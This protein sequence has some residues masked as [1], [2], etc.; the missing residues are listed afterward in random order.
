MEERY[1]QANRRNWNERASIHAGSP[2]Y[3]LDAYRAEPTR[4]SGVVRFDRPRLGDIA[5]LDAVHLQCHIGTDTLSL[6]RLG[7]NVTGLDQSEESIEIARRL[8]ADTGTDGRFEIGDVHA[9]PTL[10]ER[11]YDLVYTGVGALNWLPS[12]DAWSGV[13]DDLL[14]PGGRLFLREGHP[15]MMSLADSTDG[16]LSLGYPY[17]ETPEPMVLDET[18]T[19]TDPDAADGSSIANSRTYE[20][21]HGLGEVVTALLARGLVLRTL[22]EH[23]GLEWRMFPHMVLEDGQ[24]KLPAEQRAMVPMMYTL[25]ASKPIG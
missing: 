17:F 24:Y 21:N 12:I 22:V 25:V 2:M 16:T 1:R 15:A 19:Y 11:T 9:A 10:L 14:A 4:I 3:A 8:F 13:V 20:W 7:A 6:A 23:D 18:N 5:G